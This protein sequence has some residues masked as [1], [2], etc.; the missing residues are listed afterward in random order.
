MKPAINPE[1]FGRRV[2]LRREE[3]GL[4]Q[5]K[6]GEW[7]GHSQTNIGWIEQGKAKD[8]RKQVISLADALS[9]TPD[10]LLYEKGP[11]ETGLR[12][13]SPEQFTKIYEKLPIEVRRTLSEAIKEFTE[14]PASRKQ[15]R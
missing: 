3:L 12:V 7:A 6:L 8:P 9:T 13:L 5:T 10:W 1:E 11:K 2:R 14:P 4:S 15:A